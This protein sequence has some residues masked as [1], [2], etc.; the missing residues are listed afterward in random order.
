MSTFEK[1]LEELEEIN[2]RLREG[3]PLDKAI[4]LFEKGMKTAKSLEKDLAG[5]ERKIEILLNEP[6]S[7]EESPHLELF[8]QDEEDD[9]SQN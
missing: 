6:E 9:D 1:R 3:C 7:E 2:D 8:S 4:S 5:I